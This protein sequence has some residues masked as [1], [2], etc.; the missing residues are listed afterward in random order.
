MFHSENATQQNK[1]F[2]P[3]LRSEQQPNSE[4]YSKL[5]IALLLK[6]TYEYLCR[7]NK[8]NLL[9]YDRNICLVE[10]TEFLH[11]QDCRLYTNYQK[12]LQQIL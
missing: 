10:L 5:V 12:Y 1:I 7:V 3:P 11:K 8:T 2:L 4:T 9:Y 6:P